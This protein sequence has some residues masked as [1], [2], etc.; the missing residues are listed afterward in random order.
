VVQFDLGRLL[1]FHELG[2]F[3]ATVAHHEHT[4]TVPFGVLEV[5]EGRVLGLREK[6]TYSWRTNAGIYVLSPALVARVP[7]DVDFPLPAL[8]D[9]CLERGE[10]VG[11]FPVGGDWIDVGRLPE[12]TRAR[13]EG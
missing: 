3:A 9:Q 7:H 1:A 13:G 5:A 2:G 6:P 4:H 10:A 8:V 12:L 11:A